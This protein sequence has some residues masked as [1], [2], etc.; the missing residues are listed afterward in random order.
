M[1]I[2]QDL[3]SSLSQAHQDITGLAVRRLFPQRPHDLFAAVSQPQG[4]RMLLV[5]VPSEGL[6]LSGL[7]K[8]RAIEVRSQSLQGGARVRLSLVLIHPTF[9]DVFTTL[10]R[11]VA[12]A[13]AETSATEQAV[14]MFF[15]RIAHWRELLDAVAESGLS[16]TARRGLYGELHTLLDFLVPALSP[17]QAVAA[18]TGPSA[19]NQDF[20][21]PFCAVEVKTTVSKQPQTLTIT[22]ER[23]LDGTGIPRLFLVY[24]SLDERRGGTGRSLNAMVDALLGAVDNDPAAVALLSEQLHRVGYL[25]AQR[26]LYEEPRYTIRATHVF[27]VVEG[28]PCITERDLRPGVGDV[29]YRIELTACRPYAVDEPELR[30]S[31]RQGGTP[32]D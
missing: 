25:T 27:D 7:P 13:V 31:I 1:K 17:S 9:S 15:S 5:E 2:D 8:T 28:F 16:P 19:T 30:G 14:E 21:L 4:E 12:G 24:L 6:R 11:D 3:W 29:R 23:E 22:N 10:V 18:W 32:C 26:S 20:Q